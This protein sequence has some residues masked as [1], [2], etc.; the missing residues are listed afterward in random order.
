MHHSLEEGRYPSITAKNKTRANTTPK[1]NSQT[2]TLKNQGLRKTQYTALFEIV[3]EMWNQKQISSLAMEFREGKKTHTCSFEAQTSIWL[4]HSFQISQESVIDAHLIAEL[5]S[6]HR[7]QVLVMIL[8][9][10]SENLA[11][12]IC[13]NYNSTMVWLPLLWYW[14][15]NQQ[16]QQEGWPI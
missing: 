13:N 15:C 14:K 1:P 12:C 9:L 7:K 8:Q 16:I 3:K 11:S 4:T 10:V 6:A 5:F 2:N